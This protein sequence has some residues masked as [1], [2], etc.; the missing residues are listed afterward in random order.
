MTCTGSLN[1]LYTKMINYLNYL[2]K[3]NE[4]YTIT[5]GYIIIWGRSLGTVG[6]YMKRSGE[7]SFGS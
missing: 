7:K 1:Y 6:I 2:Y 4:V 5:T 3:T